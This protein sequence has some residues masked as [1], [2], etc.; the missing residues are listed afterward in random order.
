MN[1][2]N[3]SGARPPTRMPMFKSL[4]IGSQVDLPVG[5]QP[6]IAVEIHRAEV[7]RAEAGIARVLGGGRGG[8]VEIRR[9][10]AGGDG[11][12]RGA[13]LGGCAGGCGEIVG[14]GGQR[15]LIL[16]GRRL[17]GREA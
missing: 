12:R 10:R 15:V 11:S 13:L 17:V 5:I 14:V 1:P 4:L 16:S 2:A 8:N 3:S 7:R 9:R 6:W